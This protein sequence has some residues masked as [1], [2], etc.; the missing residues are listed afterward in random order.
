MSNRL[1]RRKW[2]TG[3]T[4]FKTV[5]CFTIGWTIVEKSWPEHDPKLTRLCDLLQTGSS[6]WCHFRWKCKQYRGLWLVKFWTCLHLQFSRKSVI[7]VM[8][9]RR[10]THLGPIVGVNEQKYPIGCVSEMKPVNHSFQSCK[11]FKNWL[12]RYRKSRPEHAQNEHVYA[13]CCR[14]DVVCDVISGENVKIIE[15]YSVLNFEVATV[16]L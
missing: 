7:Y 6:W 3:I 11:P 4:V 13:I 1:Q 10:Q 9:R 2:W 12:N 5:N 15:G 16:Q 14:P 8:R